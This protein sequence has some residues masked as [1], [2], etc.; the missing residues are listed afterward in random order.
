M[1]RISVN[2]VPASRQLAMHLRQI[3]IAASVPV[4]IR[5]RRLRHPA[6]TAAGDFL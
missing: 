3:R 5:A 6:K 4:R 2:T 1:T